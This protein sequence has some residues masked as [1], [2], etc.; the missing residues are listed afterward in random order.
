VLNLDRFTHDPGN[1][2]ADDT[3]TFNL[4][5]GQCNSIPL[6]HAATR[7]ATDYDP[8]NNFS[9]GGHMSDY[10]NSKLSR[11]HLLQAGALAGAGLALSKTLLAADAAALPLIT[12]VIPSSGEKIPVMGIG[13]NA[14]RESNY[15]DVLANIKRMHELGGTLID[16]APSYTGGESEA[17]IGRALA[18]LG[19]RDKM[20][21][22]TKFNA[23]GKGFGNTEP[24]GREAF[25]RSMKLLNKIDLL[26]VHRLD[27]LDE[28]MPVMQEYKKAGKIRYLGV[29][30]FRTEEHGRM[31]DALRKYPFDFIQIDYSMANRKA[32]EVV[33]PL[34]MERKVAVMLNVPL[35]GR[36]GS[37]FQE[38]GSR[39]LPKWAADFN[40]T[41]WSQ[42]F[43]K[44]VASHPAVTCVI[45]GSTKVSH[46]EDNQAAGRGRLPT[47]AERKRMEAFWDGKA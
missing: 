1:S 28:L 34:A 24:G 42:F 29:T 33:L 40:A 30:T 18:E 47:A 17:V 6:S 3:G 8:N 23:A 43:L 32:A 39:E 46:L 20:F 41:T 19:I 16:T 45:P 12:K 9:L 15:A 27:G 36:R 35:G 22:S 38:V 14:F 2:A 25:E 26:E 7:V 13:T 37:L 31:A 4:K 44:Y 21:I 10:G 11:R 5:S